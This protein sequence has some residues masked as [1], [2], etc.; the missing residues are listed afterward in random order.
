MKTAFPTLLFF[1]FAF[2]QPLFPQAGTLDAT[3]DGDGKVLTAFLPA[4]MDFVL[5]LAVQPD[6]KIVAAGYATGMNSQD[7]ALA[8]YHPD[9]SLDDSF[10]Q[11]GKSTLDFN[12]GIDFGRS[13][14]LQPDGKIVVAGCAANGS[15]T[16][17]AVARFLENGDPDPSFGNN[18]RQTTAV[19]AGKNDGWSVALQADGKLLVA[20][21]AY[22]TPDLGVFALARYTAQGVLDTSFGQ[23]G[24]VTTAVD[25]TNSHALA[26][27]VRP[28]G[29]IIAA[30]YAQ[31]G[32]YFDFAVVQ[33]LPDGAL[34]PDFG[35]NGRQL[36]D[37][38]GF[39]D[40]G[41]AIL[42]QPDG[43]VVVA[44]YTQAGNTQQ[45]IAL[46]RYL[47]NGAPDSSFSLDGKTVTIINGVK[48]IAQAVTLQTDGKIVVAG[49][50]YVTSF[51][52]FRFALVRYHPDGSLDAGFGKVTTAFQVG[53]DMAYAVA[54]Q[55][56]GKIVAAGGS[57]S[58]DFALARYLPGPIV[59]VHDAV[60]DAQAALLY[61][62]PVQ[63]T[64]T[65]EYTLEQ[66]VPV[67]IRLYDGLGNGIAVLADQLHQ[68]AGRQTQ[69]LSLPDGL[70]AGVYLITLI[71]SGGRTNW[72]V[73]K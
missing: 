36:T 34:D 4:G 54:I 24:V 10:G 3:F 13:M 45:S 43:K 49:Y 27:A 67:S 22:P 59:G 60:P 1:L 42:L 62:N 72:K 38:S 20:G 35:T 44:G 14:L 57:T 64:V 55:A 15:M 46:V 41:Q 48:D 11:G 52:S 32:P 9:G 7:F 47:A 26:V 30:G 51:E 70:P 56:D 65:I 2:V 50:S 58:Q 37:I 40:F 16:D 23:G 5:G 25:S 12:A 29:K 31:H 69:I 8:R 33:Y 6:Q 73:V 28:D 19:I 53:N 61:P 71:T 21:T 68:T 66:A 18:G 39:H 17:F 63:E